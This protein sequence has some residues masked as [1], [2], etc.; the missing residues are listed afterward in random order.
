MIALDDYRLQLLEDEALWL[1]G[2]G[3][4]EGVSSFLQAP[5][6][7]AWVRLNRE[8]GG[9]AWPIGAD[10]GILC[11]QIAGESH[12]TSSAEASGGYGRD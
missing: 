2:L 9:I 12:S 1:R 3:L 11:G 8:L 5:E 6:R 4:F 7:F 10:P